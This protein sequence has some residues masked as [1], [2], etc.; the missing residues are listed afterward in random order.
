MQTVYLVIGVPGSGKTWL[1]RQLGHKFDHVPH[2]DYIGPKQHGVYAKAIT[3]KAK[4][5]Q[6][7]I[8][9]EAPF[10]ISEIKLP[11]EAANVKVVPVFV[12][13]TPEVL[14]ERYRRR[15]HR[16]LPMGHL[17]R[18]VTYINRC[19]ELKAFRGTSSEVLAYLQRL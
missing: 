7:P 3:E 14:N 17:T 2:D 5:A 12:I 18:Q 13:E 1:C 10:S 6:R 15:E 19:T 8:L 16:L 9:A 11:L 4:T